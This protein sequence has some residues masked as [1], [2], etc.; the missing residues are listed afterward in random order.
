MVWVRARH[1]GGG[2]PPIGVRGDRAPGCSGWPGWSFGL[3]PRAPPLPL[4][5][6]IS[7][8]RRPPCGPRPLWTL[9]LSATARAVRVGHTCRG[10]GFHVGP[11]SGDQPGDQP[12]DQRAPEQ[13]RALGHQDGQRDPP[14]FPRPER[15]VRAQHAVCRQSHQYSSARGGPFLGMRPAQHLQRH[16][17]HRGQGRRPPGL[18]GGQRQLPPQPGRSR[19][20]RPLCAHTARR[21]GGP[22]W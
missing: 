1:L 7:P 11:L 3:P 15:Q 9:L 18:S 2:Q 4:G 13:H 16:A 12:S 14:W 8:V 6:V 19:K 20:R 5:G 17:H 21:L 10:A 22:Q